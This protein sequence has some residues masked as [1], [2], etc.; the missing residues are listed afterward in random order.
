M[1]TKS[2][3]APGIDGIQ[4]IVLKYLSKKANAQITYIFNACLKQG[5]FP[6]SWQKAKILPIQKPGKDKSLS[7]SYRP[8]SLLNTL[9][10]LLEKIILNRLHKHELQHK[11]FI[12]DQFGSRPKHWTVQQLVRLTDSVSLNFNINKST[13]ALFLNM[14]KAFDM[15]WHEVS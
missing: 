1:K 3:E 9:S 10:K 15:V 11:Q 13:C 4:N 12:P 5:Y 2:K 6:S 8:I 14:E 7:Q